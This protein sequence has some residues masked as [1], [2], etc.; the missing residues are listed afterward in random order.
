MLEA[1]KHLQNILPSP[2]LVDSINDEYLDHLLRYFDHSY[3]VVK[4]E[5]D[6]ETRNVMKYAL[7]DAIGGYLKS[8]VLPVSKYSYYGGTI[9]LDNVLKV[10]KLYDDIKKELNTNG[11]GWRKDEEL[12]NYFPIDVADFKK[13]NSRNY[14]GTCDDLT[15]YEKSDSGYA[16]PVPV[17]NWD[18]CP[19]TMFMPLKNPSLVPL[20]CSNSS[21]FLVNY[22]ELIQNCV[23]NFDNWKDFDNRFQSWLMTDVA[24]HLSD[25][26]LYVPFGGVLGLMNHS[27][28]PGN[29][30]KSLKSGYN[31]VINSCNTS[32]FL[33]SGKKVIIAII[34]FV[35][36]VWCIPALYY[37]V[38]C[39]K[40]KRKR[41]WNLL[42]CFKRKNKKDAYYLGTTDDDT[43]SEIHYLS[44]SSDRSYNTMNLQ[45]SIYGTRYSTDSAFSRQNIPYVD[46]RRTESKPLIKSQSK[47]KP[48]P[49]DIIETECEVDRKKNINK[50]KSRQSHKSNKGALS[51]EK[52]L[53]NFDY[54]Q[55][56][57][58]AKTKEAS[59]GGTLE[60]NDTGT[61]GHRNPSQ[62]LSQKLQKESSK[63]IVSKALTHI[64][65]NCKT[66]Q[67]PCTNDIIAD[68]MNTYSTKPVAP[69]KKEKKI[70]RIRKRTTE[71][72]RQERAANNEKNV[73]I[74]KETAPTLHINIAQPETEIKV[75]ISRYKEYTE[76]NVRPSKIPRLNAAGAKE[77]SEKPIPQK[78]IPPH[79]LKAE[80]AF[81]NDVDIELQEKDAEKLNVTL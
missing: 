67:H 48:I 65:E 58:K 53:Q 64:E 38:C 54:S 40:K 43:D 16:V 31:K 15:F 63:G 7:S 25:D 36:L 62:H 75:G 41:K 13:R 3:D 61:A 30:F 44:S 18:I 2:N 14:E 20:D 68:T 45:P 35:E 80:K 11:E 55:Y 76:K 24:P 71:I 66:L 12:I 51:S 9:S 10:N 27:K 69:K 49:R 8:W 56:L 5:T 77:L 46:D 81:E 52:I 39:K 37:V 50:S 21:T 73:P 59:V 4:R 60:I 1:R 34:V 26:C 6:P 57:M 42:F 32:F 19:S 23:N 72:R 28:L 47:T 17:I 33:F 79:W 78:R 22:Y 74:R 70:F 29:F